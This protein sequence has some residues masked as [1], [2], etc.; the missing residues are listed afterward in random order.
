M[1][2]NDP[3]P[4]PD[5]AELAVKIGMAMREAA[6]KPD[7]GLAPPRLRARF[8]RRPRP[9]LSDPGPDRLVRTIRLHRDWHDVQ[10]RGPALY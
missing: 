9:G 6:G 4:C 7:C 1:F 2:F 8:R 3:I 5:P 10:P